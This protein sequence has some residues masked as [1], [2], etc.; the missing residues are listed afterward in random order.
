MHVD[1][2]MGN[3]TPPSSAT[4]ISIMEYFPV[5]VFIII[6]CCKCAPRGRPR[7]LCK[8][9]RMISLPLHYPRVIMFCNN[10]LRKEY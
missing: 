2:H 1:I 9:C 7:L 5:M 6:M 8:G 3:P 10:E 4:N